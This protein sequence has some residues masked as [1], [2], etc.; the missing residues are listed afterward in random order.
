M[1]GKNCRSGGGEIDNGKLTV[2]SGKLK[3]VLKF[4]EIY[5]FN[6]KLI[7]YFMKLKI[8]FHFQLSTVNCQLKIK[9][10]ILF[11]SPKNFR[12]KLKNVYERINE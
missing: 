3:V 6:I 8:T 9:F 1:L 12:L 10:N 2:E 5:M 11:T 7:L 4:Y